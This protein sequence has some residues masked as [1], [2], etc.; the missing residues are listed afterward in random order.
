MRD[1][2]KYIFPELD[3]VEVRQT[4]LW[5]RFVKRAFDFFFSLFLILLLSPLLIIVAI[6]VAISSHGTPFYG[7]E[8]VGRWGKK[9]LVFKF[10]SMFVDANTHP[11]KYLNK[12]QLEQFYN[13]R[14]VDNDPRIT[15]IG[16]FIRKTS[17]DELPQLF[18]ILFGSMSFIGPR[19]IT[20]NE[21]DIHFTEKQAKIYQSAKPGLTGLWQTSGRNNI[22]FRNGERQK[23]E[24]EYFRIRGIRTDIKIMFKTIGA[25]LKQE[26]VK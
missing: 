10:R 7:D 1:Q 8:R 3:N 24:L 19:P 9:L 11:E 16:R 21:F 6:A 20:Q 15:K 14:K 17:I 23:I 18:N 12:E 25:V 5:Y 4:G 26:G 22:E 2:Q 13:E